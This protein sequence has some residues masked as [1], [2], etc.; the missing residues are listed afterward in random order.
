MNNDS[1]EKDASPYI[2]DEAVLP[3][4]DG[5]QPEVLSYR[6]IF[7]QKTTDSQPDVEK[8]DL[9]ATEITE[10][11]NI[12]LEKLEKTVSKCPV[13][14]PEETYNSVWETS[15]G[16]KPERDF[17]SDDIKQAEKKTNL[18]NFEEI[19]K[20][21]HEDLLEQFSFSSDQISEEFA[22]LRSVID[23]NIDKDKLIDEKEELFRK[24][25]YDL[26][27]YQSGIERSL[28]APLLK[29]AIKWYQ[30]VRDM[31]RF[32]E[33]KAPCFGS[34]QKAY[35][36][37]LRE[38]ENFGELILDSLENYDVL[39]IAP[40]KNTPFDRSIHEA[41]EAVVTTD[42]SLNNL[43]HQCFSVGFRYS[44]GKII[45]YAKVSVYKFEK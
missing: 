40:E 14:E 37:L 3:V 16:M 8:A 1:K 26:K 18:A 10:T 7:D 6:E 41:M 13:N 34:G 36:D 22:K 12:I 27:K 9:P 31:H 39:I 35:N 29:T 24:V 30:R 42:S 33:A 38:F 5:M 17:D 2:S 20:M 43:I 11:S 28:L 44:D 19:R 4:S 23:E 45:Q 15:N 25:Y 32:Y 21:I